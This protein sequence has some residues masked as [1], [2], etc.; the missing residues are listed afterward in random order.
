MNATESS[1]LFFN[2]H[3]RNCTYFI[4][5]VL[6]KEKEKFN[7][8]YTHTQSHKQNDPHTYTAQLTKGKC[9]RGSYRNFW[10][11]RWHGRRRRRRRRWWWFFFWIV[12]NAN[13]VLFQFQLLFLLFRFISFARTR[14][15]VF[16]H[17]QHENPIFPHPLCTL[18]SRN[19][20]YEVT[21][22]SL[23]LFVDESIFVTLCLIFV[24]FLDSFTSFLFSLLII[25]SFTRSLL[26]V[27]VFSFNLWLRF[28]DFNLQNTQVST[29]TQTREKSQQ[30][31]QWWCIHTSN[32]SKS[33]SQMWNFFCFDPNEIQTKLCCVC[34]CNL[35]SILHC[36]YVNIFFSLAYFSLCRSLS[37]ILEWSSGDLFHS[38]LLCLHVFIYV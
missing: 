8:C 16:I 34:I 26:I 15:Y 30:Q 2:S 32:K 6:A 20:L 37:L 5:I 33:N 10:R 12:R 7:K 13:R 28:L 24:C 36:V 17:I 29:D 23:C 35:S 19:L 11:F 14:L 21:F 27:L 22:L 25:V 9:E 18:K 3:L 4:L 31:Q 38:M 1:Q